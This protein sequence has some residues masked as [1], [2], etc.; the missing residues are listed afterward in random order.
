VHTYKK[1][2]GRTSISYTDAVEEAICFGWIDGQIKKIDDDRYMQRFTPRKPKSLWSEINVDRAKKMIAL[3]Y[4]TE[5]GLKA[6]EEGTKTKER[7]PSSKNFSVP[8][9]LRTALSK[10]KKAWNNFQSFS[11]SAQLAYVY[12]VTSAKTE[13]TRQKRIEKIIERLS[14][15]K[16]FGEV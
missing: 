4:M 15:K 10:N 12:W 9:Y 8:L 6:L 7:I 16:K 1:H 5:I 14:M 11:P 3:G 13:E 2:T